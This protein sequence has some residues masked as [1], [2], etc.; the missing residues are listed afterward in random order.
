M[1]LSEEHVEQ[2]Q[3]TFS[4][5]DKNGSGTLEIKELNYLLCK[6]LN[7]QLDEVTLGEIVSEITDSDAS[8]DGIT[9]ELFVKA[10]EPILSSISPDEAAVRSF[11]VMDHDGDGN[12]AGKELAP[13][14]S[15]VAGIKLKEHQVEDIMSSTGGPD[16][17]IKLADYK[18]VVGGA[19]PAQHRHKKS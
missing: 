6:L 4:M 18:R 10:L 9:Y 12:I 5:L 7:K 8:G 14:M 2:L 16:G 3:S 15:A 1:P 13:L 19:V 11:N 17:T